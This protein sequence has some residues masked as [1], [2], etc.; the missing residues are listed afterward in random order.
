MKSHAPGTYTAPMFPFIACQRRCVLTQA[1]ASAR[2][3]TRAS[4]C[5]CDLL[6]DS[7]RHSA[8]SPAPAA[9]RRA[10]IGCCHA[11]QPA[12]LDS[13]RWKHHKSKL[14]QRCKSQG[15]ILYKFH[16][17]TS[18]N[19]LKLI[20]RSNNPS[21]I[22]VASECAPRDTSEICGVLNCSTNLHR[23]FT[24]RPHFK[25]SKLHMTWIV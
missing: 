4:S 14:L 6:A 19:K 24:D 2:R 7:S 9:R 23:P 22:A 11:L 10:K 13:N 8:H 1:L 12:V 21:S 20:F 17:S 5:G 25:F 16:D 18:H 3:H 15:F